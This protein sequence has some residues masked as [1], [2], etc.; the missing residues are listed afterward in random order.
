[1]CR[2]LQGT[3][4]PC[5]PAP[6]P[7][8]ASASAPLGPSANHLKAEKPFAA[9]W[10]GRLLEQLATTSTQPHAQGTELGNQL[11]CIQR[12]RKAYPAL[13]RP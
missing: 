11:I 13:G 6:A 12:W 9:N 2:E 3:L 1:M 7:A 8:S 4:S 10:N 5:A